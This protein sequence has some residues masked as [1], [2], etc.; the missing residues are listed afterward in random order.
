MRKPVL[1]PLCTRSSFTRSR[2]KESR[3]FA[4]AVETSLVE[5]PVRLEEL[6]MANQYAGEMPTIKRN[7][8]SEPARAGEAKDIR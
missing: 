7:F 5:A 4:S 6:L 8:R 2:V 1:Q 3:G